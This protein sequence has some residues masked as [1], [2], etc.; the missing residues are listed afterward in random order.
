MKYLFSK[1]DSFQLLEN[2]K[3]QLVQHLDSIS[4]AD[5]LNMDISQLTNQI[6][7]KFYF[8]VPEIFEDKIEN[9]F[10]RKKVATDG[11][12]NY[13]HG[14]NHGNS[15][16][17]G[18]EYQFF[19]PFTGDSNLFNVRPSLYSFHSPSAEVRNSELLFSYDSPRQ[20]SEEI[21]RRFDRDFSS[22]KQTFQ[23]L[24]NQ[25]IE[26]NRML[27][28]FIEEKIKKKTEK[29]QKTH[30]AAASLGFPLR[31]RGNAPRTFVVPEVKRKIAIPIYN[32]KSTNAVEP[33]IS[34]VEY[35]HILSLMKNMALIM[36]RSPTA[37]QHIGEE[38]LRDFFLVVLNSQ[39]E[40][41][42]TGETFNYGGKTDILIRKDGKNIF[43]AECKF[44]TGPTGFLET[45]DQLLKYLSWRDSK[46]AI[47][48]FNKNKDFSNVIDQIP[49][50]IKTHPNFVKNGKPSTEPSE[51][52][53]IFHNSEDK[54]KEIYLAVQ[55]YNVPHS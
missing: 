52:N 2:V 53:F 25:L 3:N 18:A 20:D 37:F 47:V 1:I 49:N 30:Q 29:L 26:F 40:G 43:I 21:K 34:L 48:L 5:L 19:L 33:T 8:D 35:E 24:K 55:A 6:F 39:Y 23:H 12:P 14:F 54:Q 50:L 28:T 22:F 32:P 46:A 9:D 45:I 10:I 42:A 38:H 16:V 27:P 51:F 13:F 41:Q 11:D 17:D 15:V 4:E 44:W 7:Q 36:E 31:R